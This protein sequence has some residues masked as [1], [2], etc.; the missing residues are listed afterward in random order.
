MAAAGEVL[1][2]HMP[3]KVELSGESPAELHVLAVDDSLVDRIVIEKLLK[4]SSCKGESLN[5]FFPVYQGERVLFIYIYLF[6][7]FLKW[8]FFFS[9]CCGEWDE[10]SAISGIRWGEELSWVKCKKL[11]DLIVTLFGC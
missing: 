1:R 7:I 10:S 5:F 3:E 6:I 11:F 2:P 4:I 9:D 8:D